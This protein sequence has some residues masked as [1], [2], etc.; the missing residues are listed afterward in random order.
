MKRI[1]FLIVVTLLLLALS[2]CSEKCIANDKQTSPSQPD[3]QPTLNNAET[4]PTEN[5]TIPEV[6][7]IPVEL[8]LDNYMEYFEF[9]ERFYAC[10]D[11]FG[12]VSA[13]FS[14]G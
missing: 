4:T 3:N 8:T 5:P 11:E 7:F 9:R 14:V 1:I 13:L 12:V 2:S 6:E 10:K